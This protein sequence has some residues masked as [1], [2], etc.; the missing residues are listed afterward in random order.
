MWDL[1]RK[2]RRIVAD[3]VLRRWLMGRLLG[4]YPGPPKFTP[5]LPPYLQK[6]LPLS[7]SSPCPPIPFNEI[8]V[9][10]PTDTFL[11][12]LPAADIQIQPG[13]GKEIFTRS[14]ADLES[15]LALYRFAWLPLLGKHICPGWVQNLW[16]AWQTRYQ[17]PDDSWAWHPY[18]AAER[19]VNLIDFGRQFGL[20]APLEDTLEILARHG[21]AIASRLEYFGEHHTSNHLANNGRGLYR[22]GLA[23]GIPS[24]TKIGAAI[25]LNEAERIF[26]PSGILREGSSHYH[27][28]LARNY[29]DSW[30]AAYTHDHSEEPRLR[31]ITRR[32]LGAAR[33]ITLP[34]GLP[35]IGDISP[36]CPPPHL[37]SLVDGEGGWLD[38]LPSDNRAAFLNL[39]DQA[40]IPD[41]ETLRQDGWLRFMSNPW[42]GLWHAAPDGWSPMPGHGHQDCGSFELHFDG[43]PVLID[44]GRG[45]YCTA[46]DDDPNVQALAHNSLTVDEANPYPLNRPYYDVCFRHRVAGPPPELTFHAEGVFLRHRGFS[47][48]SGVGT[49]SRSW[50]FK[51][52]QLLISD[53]LEGTGRHT[54]RRSFITPLKVIPATE[55]VIL[56]DQNSGLRFCIACPALRIS[57]TMR[58]I[59]YG[60]SRP[61]TMIEVTVRTQLPWHDTVE[62]KRL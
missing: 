49:L 36:D 26:L 1:I 29:A 22:L 19:A 20:P 62:I 60:Q 57:P 41:F 30:L 24:L 37:F 15:L 9:D 35:L 13:A 23:L 21:Q 52:D 34:G 3:P 53:D 28:L 38:W 48:L 46:S 16:R 43:K 18:T 11:L 14:F 45:D 12:P 44:P 47:R 17:R 25:L 32:L 33:A 31:E 8:N 42:S 40:L 51:S 5:H 61:A 27:F 56:E 55:A 6:M 2:G 7:I 54:I 59:A 4:K 50:R 10:S 39:R 58:W